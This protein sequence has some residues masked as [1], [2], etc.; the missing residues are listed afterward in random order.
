M[1]GP[2]H[3]QQLDFMYWHAVSKMRISL[4]KDAAVLFRLIAA[5]EPKRVD[6]LLGRVYCLIREGELQDASDLLTQ[7]NVKNLASVEADLIVRLKRRC[8]FELNQGQQ[9]RAA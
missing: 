1:N 6:A 8:Q 5:V 9:P 3:A 7:V 4:F 2:F